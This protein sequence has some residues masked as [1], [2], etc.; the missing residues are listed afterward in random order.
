[1][2]TQKVEVAD[3]VEERDD[4]QIVKITR[5]VQVPDAE[6]LIRRFSRFSSG[7]PSGAHFNHSEAS[8]L[9]R[10]AYDAPADVCGADSPA[11]QLRSLHRSG[12]DVIVVRSD[13][14][15]L[16]LA[17]QANQ[18]PQIRSNAKSPVSS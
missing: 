18:Q 4:L 9:L 8:N 11:E 14:S 10:N 16:R 3:C 1:M 6:G 7:G 2:D 5:R 12:D 13:R 15:H 17:A